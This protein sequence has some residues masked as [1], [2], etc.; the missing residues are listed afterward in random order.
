MKNIIYNPAISI[1]VVALLGA[2]LLCEKKNGDNSFS[3]RDNNYTS[4]VVSQNVS[5]FPNSNTSATQK[6]N[7]IEQYQ[8]RKTSLNSVQV[9]LNEKV[10]STDPTKTTENAVTIIQATEES[11]F[12]PIKMDQYP[13]ETIEMLAESGDIQAMRNLADRYYFTMKHSAES[14]EKTKEL[15]D[16]AL[17]LY[18][19]TVSMGNIRSA[20]ALSQIAL[21]EKKPEQ[22]YAWHLIAKKLG[23][24]QERFYESHFADSLSEEQIEAGK[25]IYQLESSRLYSRA[26]ELNQKT[27]HLEVLPSS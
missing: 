16:K 4:N 8:H 26:I 10:D 22:A 11:Y 20:S 3:K 24:R 2:A 23:D 6:I 12:D 21:L 27:D 9:S 19:D 13:L 17:S 1:I 18:K 25:S 15:N 7:I 14:V 5:A